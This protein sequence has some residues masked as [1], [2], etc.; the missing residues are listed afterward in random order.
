F[1]SDADDL[2]AG[3]DN[4][5]DDVFLRDLGTQTTV[6]LSEL[7]DGTDLDGASEYPELTPDGRFVV[8]ETRPTNVV[9]GNPAATVMIVLLD[10]TRGLFR[11]LSIDSTGVVANAIS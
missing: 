5:W 6:R 9:D 4:R 1:S 3:D 10:R 11:R 2:V 7:A 8:F